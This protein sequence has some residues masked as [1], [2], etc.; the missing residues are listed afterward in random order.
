MVSFIAQCLCLLIATLIGRFACKSRN[1][2]WLIAFTGAFGAMVSSILYDGQGAFLLIL[3]A[4]LIYF[5]AVAGR[6]DLR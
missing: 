6:S 3:Y 5:F 4:P 1:A 2:I